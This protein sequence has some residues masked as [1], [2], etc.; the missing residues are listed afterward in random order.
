MPM[1]CDDD[2]RSSASAHF[3]PRGALCGGDNGERRGSH[4]TSARRIFAYAKL[5]RGDST[6]WHDTVSAR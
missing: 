2:G 6:W 1:P 3:V 5:P 4:R